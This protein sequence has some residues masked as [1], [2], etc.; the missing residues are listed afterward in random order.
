MNYTEE[1]HEQAD[2]TT[3]GKTTG[4]RETALEI[5]DTGEHRQQWK[6]L[7]AASIAGV[8]CKMST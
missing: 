4:R 7:V 1:D 5:K 3:F 2:V 8:N 6:E